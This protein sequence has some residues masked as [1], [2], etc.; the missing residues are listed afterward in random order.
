MVEEFPARVAR[1]PRAVAGNRA[2][3]WF[4]EAIRL[5]KVRPIVFSVMALVVLAASIAFDALPVAG[6]VSSN[7]IAPLLACGFLYGSLAADTGQKP[8][9]A[10][11]F[12]IFTAP[13]RAQLAVIAAGFIVTLIEAA[14]AWSLAEV[15]LFTGSQAGDLTPA[16]VLAIYA[17]GIVA[18][19]PVQFVPMAVLF[20]GERPLAAFASSARACFMNPRPMLL[21]ALYCYAL[22]MTAL[23]TMGVGLVL[24]LPWIAIASYAAW[25]DIYGVR[26]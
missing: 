14:V 18:S 16:T 10:H 19:M 21:L 25:K 7:V 8:R 4:G 3:V 6:F 15:N 5:W 1:A 11:L 22:L 13:P 20:D 2:L 23:A 26:A 12:T 9:L 17:V 24:A